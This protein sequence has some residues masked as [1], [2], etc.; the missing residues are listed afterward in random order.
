MKKKTVQN[1]RSS[2]TH[3]DFIE[4]YEKL[5]NSFHFIVNSSHGK[6]NKK[7][8]LFK[9]F[10]KEMMECFTLYDQKQNKSTCIPETFNARNIHLL[11]SKSAQV[12]LDLFQA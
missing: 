10:S 1:V 7:I 5:K 8:P 2:M 6:R 12:C 11:K 3:K 4:I 9:F